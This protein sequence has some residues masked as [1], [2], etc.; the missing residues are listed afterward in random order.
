MNEI[1]DFSL[2]IFN[3]SLTLLLSMGISRNNSKSIYGVILL[4]PKKIKFCFI[5]ESEFLYS[6]LT[7]NVYEYNLDYL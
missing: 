3:L 1:K 2:F 4:Q 6:L 5:F 7:L